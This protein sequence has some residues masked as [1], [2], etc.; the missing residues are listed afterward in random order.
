LQIVTL[1]RLEGVTYGLNVVSKYL[2][3]SSNHLDASRTLGSLTFLPIPAVTLCLAHF[4]KFLNVVTRRITVPLKLV[5][6][7]AVFLFQLVADRPCSCP[8]MPDGLLVVLAP[9]CVI[10]AGI[11]QG[12]GSAKQESGEKL[13]DD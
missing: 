6:T 3:S 8:V 13:H 2:I 9:V 7:K 4:L 5:T 11:Y 12:S 1:G 10:S